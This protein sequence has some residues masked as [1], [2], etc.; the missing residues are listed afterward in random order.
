[1]AHQ[2]LYLQDVYSGEQLPLG[3]LK[4]PMSASFAGSRR[5]GASKTACETRGAHRADETVHRSPLLQRS[6][7][8]SFRPLHPARCDMIVT[9]E[10]DAV[11]FPRQRNPKCGFIFLRVEI[12]IRAA[13]K[14]GGIVSGDVPA[15]ADV[16]PNDSFLN[17]TIGRPLTEW[18]RL[19][20]PKGF[21]SIREIRV[22]RG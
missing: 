6:G 16:S 13:T 5:R 15:T 14:P 20:T 3:R 9:T 11:R 22:I 10:K 2:P 21:F 19:G 17:S 8:Q 18:R 4:K 12:L 7:V 1:M